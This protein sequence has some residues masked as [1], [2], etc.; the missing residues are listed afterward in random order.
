MFI[1]ETDQCLKITLDHFYSWKGTS[2][3]SII[4]FIESDRGSRIIDKQLPNLDM[5]KEDFVVMLI[6]KA[7]GSTQTTLDS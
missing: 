5:T 1:S 4:D 7:D 2:K 3:L 6:D